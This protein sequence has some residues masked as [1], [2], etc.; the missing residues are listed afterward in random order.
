MKAAVLA[1]CS[2]E[3]AAISTGKVP[4]LTVLSRRWPLLRVA[5]PLGLAVHLYRQAGP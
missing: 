4:T 1:L 3:V 5:L 2:W